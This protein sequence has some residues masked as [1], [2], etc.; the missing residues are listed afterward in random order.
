V[1][2]T[3]RDVTSTTRAGVRAQST[4][5]A[6]RPRDSLVERDLRFSTNPQLQEAFVNSSGKIRLGM[7]LEELDTL[8]GTISVALTRTHTHARGEREMC[9][10]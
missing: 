3:H 10:T 4:V 6:K 9:L 2:E 5:A 1:V 7:V 8:A